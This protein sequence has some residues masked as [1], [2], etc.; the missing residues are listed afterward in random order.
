MLKYSTN[1]L[2][3]SL[4]SLKDASNTQD[5]FKYCIKFK[6]C[7]TCPAHGTC[8]AE[9]HL[10]CDDG[11][12]QEDRNCVENQVILEQ[13]KMI[14][15]NFEAQLKAAKGSYICGKAESA[16]IKFKTFF[17]QLLQ[18]AKKMYPDDPELFKNLV[19]KILEL[20]NTKS[21][22]IDIDWKHEDSSD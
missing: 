5:K 15:K 9:G 17:D 19:D 20:L 11:Y 21:D 16:E 22:S 13:A 3:C 7:T 6:N 14:L 10:T 1:E 2:D 12:I 8:D 4:E 18:G